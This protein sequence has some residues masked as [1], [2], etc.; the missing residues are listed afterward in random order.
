MNKETARLLSV[1]LVVFL[2][3][4]ALARGSALREAVFFSH[5]AAMI[6]YLPVPDDGFLA[7]Q[8]RR[9]LEWSL[10]ILAISVYFYCLLAFR[11]QANAWMWAGAV[12]A[13][14]LQFALAVALALV[15]ARFAWRWS[16]LAGNFMNFLALLLVVFLPL[17]FYAAPLRRVLPAGWVDLAFERGV[18][19]QQA[20]WLLLFLLPLAALA[21]AR[22]SLTALRAELHEC[23]RNFVPRFPSLAS[24]EGQAGDSAS[25]AVE[26]DQKDPVVQ[27]DITEWSRSRDQFAEL[28]AEDSVR[29]GGLHLVPD[30]SA[31]GWMESLAARWLRPREFE[32]A[33]FLLGDNIGWWSRRWRWA[34]YLCVAT[35]L[36]ALIPVIPAWIPLCLALAVWCGVPGLGGWW[37]GFVPCWS[38][39][40]ALPFHAAYPV[41]Y[42]EMSKVILKCNLVRLLFFAPLALAVGLVVGWRMGSIGAG[43][44]F[45]GAV[46]FLA[47][48]LQPLV[49]V[50]KFSEGSNDKALGSLRR[51]ALGLGMMSMTL[52]LMPVVFVF[53]LIPTMW[54][55]KALAYFVGSGLIIAALSAGGWWL[56]EKA[57]DRLWFDQV[58]VP[59]KR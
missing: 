55:E 59:E 47:G 32:V 9:H 24:E 40:S 48:A 18:L 39:S 35:M 4:M 53:L 41:T 44:L 34:G 14:A 22:P 13:G 36:L 28:K 57:Y 2:S 17:R 20:A 38:G 43:L 5:E 26:P 33:N 42:R 16:A 6:F 50:F 7:W 1:P 10:P 54:E 49:V 3:G 8:Y 56:Y 27:E 45:S 58:T 11:A 31:C 19:S 15:V 37:T 46:L 51:W 21:F 30:W 12:L 29:A 23:L 25:R 52:A